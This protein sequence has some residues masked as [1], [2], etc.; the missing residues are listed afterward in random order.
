MLKH[1]GL[2]MSQACPELVSAKLARPRS[3]HI[4]PIA[5]AVVMVVV[6]GV[7]G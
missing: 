6:V 4:V 3:Y 2:T 5:M 1:T 7:F